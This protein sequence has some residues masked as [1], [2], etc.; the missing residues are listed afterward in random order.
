MNDRRHFLK[1]IGA[2]TS[3]LV[4]GCGDDGG[5]QSEASGSFSGGNTKTLAV[6]VITAISGQPVVIARDAKGVYAMST[7]CTHEQCNMNSSNGEIANTGLKCSCHG[8]D[9]DTNGNATAGPAKGQLKHFE[10]TISA[11]GDIT[12]NAGTSV[13]G[14]VRVAVPAA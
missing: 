3:T 2:A 9:F 8:S 7:I 13:G 14:D 1:V 6:G 4:I 5:G 11:A 12:I 10:V